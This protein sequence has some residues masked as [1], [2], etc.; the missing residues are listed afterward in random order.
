MRADCF[1]FVRRTGCADSHTPGLKSD[2]AISL[3]AGACDIELRTFTA[4]ATGSG[5]LCLFQIPRSVPILGRLIFKP[6]RDVR[7]GIS[8]QAGPALGR[9][10]AVDTEL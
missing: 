4:I 2:L 7:T 3:N 1:P 9:D 10:D 6:S 8:T 5:L